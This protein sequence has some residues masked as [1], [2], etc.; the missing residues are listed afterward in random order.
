MP[1]STVH[2]CHLMWCFGCNLT[3]RAKTYK[4]KGRKAFAVRRV[5]STT[6]EV[7]GGVMVFGG[8]YGGGLWLLWLSFECSGD[9]VVLRWCDER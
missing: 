7:L 3:P 8:M 9:D 6:Y 5:S 2:K 4:F 1:S